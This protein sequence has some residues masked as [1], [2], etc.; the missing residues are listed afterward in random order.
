MN[1]GVTHLGNLLFH[2]RGVA[3]LDFSTD[4]SLLVSVGSDDAHHVAIWDWQNGVLLAQARG[5]NTDVYQ[6]A[7][8]PVNYQGIGAVED[9]D[10]VT[11]TLITVSVEAAPCS[12]KQCKV[13]RPREGNLP[14]DFSFLSRFG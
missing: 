6:V 11:Y 3:C 4:G 12:E 13:E 2:S 7:F 9:L 10:D 8:S 1:S 5:Y 14:V